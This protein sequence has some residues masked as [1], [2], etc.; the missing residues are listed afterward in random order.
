M[1]SA[2]KIF[3]LEQPR[4]ATVFIVPNEYSEQTKIAVMIAVIIVAFEFA[5][6]SLKAFIPL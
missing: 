2:V 5:M 3:S 4:Q 1:N 6:P